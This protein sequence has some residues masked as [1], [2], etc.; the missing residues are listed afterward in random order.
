M[1]YLE[2]PV[3]IVALKSEERAV[4]VSPSMELFVRSISS[5]TADIKLEFCHTARV[6]A[7]RGCAW[8]SQADDLA[9]L[10]LLSEP[11]ADGAQAPSPSQGFAPPVDP[12]QITLEHDIGSAVTGGAGS[13][14]AVSSSKG[15][16]HGDPQRAGDAMPEKRLPL[17]LELIRPLCRGLAHC[18]LHPSSSQDLK[19][20][21]TSATQALYARCL[22]DLI[23]EGILATRSLLQLQSSHGSHSQSH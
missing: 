23:P 9:K 2:A 7:L 8:A 3:D 6:L 21:A 22:H 4:V 1:E 15:N 16:G 13:A 14:V 5:A 20:A 10:A 19:T 11:L 17:S 18:L 12:E